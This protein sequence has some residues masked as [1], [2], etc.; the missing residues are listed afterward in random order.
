MAGLYIY[1]IWMR[2]CPA[3]RLC[4]CGLLVCAVLLH[5]RNYFFQEKNLSNVW[6][7]VNDS[8]IREATPVTWHPRSAGA[9]AVRVTRRTRRSNTVA[10]AMT[11]QRQHYRQLPLSRQLPPVWLRDCW[12]SSCCS[13]RPWATYRC[14]Y[15]RAYLS[16]QAANMA[17]K[18]KNDTAAIGPCQMCRWVLV[19]YEI[20]WSRH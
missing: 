10:A 15:V 4:V 16:V 2:K 17:I 8:A 5:V 20:R 13:W 1:V 9:C 3:S 14:V 12:T 18:Q 7:A 6:T 11:S 19:S